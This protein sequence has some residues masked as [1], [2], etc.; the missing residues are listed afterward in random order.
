[1]V[2]PALRMARLPQGEFVSV[3]MPGQQDSLPEKSRRFSRVTDAG[4]KHRAGLTSASALVHQARGR[5][6][7]RGVA[8]CDSADRIAG[9]SIVASNRP[10]KWR[11][12]RGRQLFQEYEPCAS[13]TST[14]RRN[15]FCA[16]C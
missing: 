11:A 2:S 14:E 15:S 12:S 9:I 6:A 7:L 1:M 10:V 5:G 4:L 16:T 13:V 3:I 8:I